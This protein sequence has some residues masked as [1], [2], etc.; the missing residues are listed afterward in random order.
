MLVAQ[1]AANGDQHAMSAVAVR[2]DDEE[3]CARRLV[4]IRA[5][6]SNSLK[7]PTEPTELRTETEIHPKKHVQN[8]GNLFNVIHTCYKQKRIKQRALVN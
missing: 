5:L 4:G 6:L 8:N 2:L 3:E 7:T 1:L